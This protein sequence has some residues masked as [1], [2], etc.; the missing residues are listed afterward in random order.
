M[1]DPETRELQIDQ[2]QRELAEREQAGD[3]ESP[4][5][6]RAHERR[7]DKH[8]YLREKLRE[9]AASEEET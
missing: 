6:Q 3:A 9:R 8:S 2:V 7:A 1:E 5:E 4:A